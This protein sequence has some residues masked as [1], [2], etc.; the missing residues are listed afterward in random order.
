MSDF[1]GFKE[2]E[3]EFVKLEVFFYGNCKLLIWKK[4]F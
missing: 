3:R 2:K 1:G 4:I